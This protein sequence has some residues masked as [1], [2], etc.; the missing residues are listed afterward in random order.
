MPAARDGK[1]SK[2]TISNKTHLEG[3]RCHE[4]I[5]F[6]VHERMGAKCC[7]RPTCPDIMQPNYFHNDIRID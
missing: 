5:R 7:F 6:T 4:K 1:G 3:R 2:K